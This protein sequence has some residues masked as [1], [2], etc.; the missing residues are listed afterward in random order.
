MRIAT[1]LSCLLLS[2]SALAWDNFGH[3]LVAR[4]AYSGLEPEVRAKVDELLG[5]GVEAF[6]QASVWADQ[7]KSKRPDTRPWHYVNIPLDAEGYDQQRDCPK[8]TC[9]IAKTE[10]FIA[11]LKSDAS[12]DKKRE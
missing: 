8:S 3:R 9:V 2:V 11:V 1:F 4:V 12:A 7:I 6:A 5:G 10:E